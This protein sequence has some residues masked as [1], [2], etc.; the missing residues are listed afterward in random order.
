ML[1]TASKMI[2]QRKKQY[3]FLAQS[4]LKWPLFV[5]NPANVTK[6]LE[7][8]CDFEISFSIVSVNTLVNDSIVTI[9]N[10]MT[11]FLKT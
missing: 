5:G 8:Y 10:E 11:N 6:K 9:A 3:K 1:T 7:E 4:F 2:K